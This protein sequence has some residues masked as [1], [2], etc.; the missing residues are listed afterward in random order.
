MAQTVARPRDGN[1]SELARSSSP[2]KV[3]GD[4]RFRFGR[5]ALG[6]IVLLGLALRL[7]RLDAQ[8]LWYDEAY[9]VDL[10]SRQPTEIVFGVI[11]DHLP[12]YFGLLHFWIAQAGQSEFAIRFLSVLFGVAAIPA[13]CV[14]AR[15]LLSPRAGLI[16]AFITT[17]SPYLIHYSQETR[18]YSMVVFQVLVSTYVLLR[19][20]GG[21]RR[22][23]IT[24]AFVAATMAYTHYYCLPFLAGQALLSAIL[25][26][27]DVRRR[28]S[29]QLRCLA[30]WLLA[31]ISIGLVFLP[32]AVARAWV[33]GGFVAGTTEPLSITSMIAKCLVVFSLGHSTGLS[34]V[35]IP[36]YPLSVSDHAIATAS[37]GGFALLAVLGTAVPT[38]RAWRYRSHVSSAS[39]ESGDGLS[40]LLSVVVL[41][42]VAVLGVYLASVGHRDFTARYLTAIVPIYFLILASGLA[43]LW[44]RSVSLALVGVIFVLLAWGYPLQRYFGDERFARDDFRSL[45]TYLAA[46][47]RANEVVVCSGEYW[48]MAVDYYRPL[49]EPC[50]GIVRGRPLDRT[51][52][53]GTLRALTQEREF[54]WLVL[55][56]D[57]V[58]DPDGHL[59]NWLDKTCLPVVERRF[60][61]G[62]RVRGYHTR[63]PLVSEDSVPNRA[64]RSFGSQI[65]LV[66]HEI[67]PAPPGSTSNVILYWTAIEPVREDYVVYVHLVSTP[68]N[69]WAQHDA[70]PL[71]GSYGTSKWSVGQT[72]RDERPLLI[73]AFTPPGEYH[74]EVGLYDSSTGQRVGGPDVDRVVLGPIK[75]GPTL[76]GT[77]L[78]DNVNRFDAR[79]SELIRLVGATDIQTVRPGQDLRFDLYW[80][81][82]RPTG[83]AYTTFIHVV[84]STGHIV[85]QG[86]APPTLGVYPTT[87]WRTGEIIRDPRAVRIPGDLRPGRYEV[88]V[89]LYDTETGSRLPVNPPNPAERFLAAWLKLA[90]RQISEGDALRLAEIEIR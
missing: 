84:D 4:R 24:Y 86:D 80:R 78:P 72:L 88:F 77:Q 18:M 35:V 28:R 90:A 57:Y 23:W 38:I 48:T 64:P 49:D 55:W 15:R 6:L 76:D 63:P 81:A 43:A 14:L 2:H 1:S 33:F 58:S 50:V 41:M 37:V 61:G 17:L 31:E 40:F 20:C 42:S 54:I 39:H 51:M 12:L 36:S 27:L 11:G 22:F 29:D 59:V 79:F 62:I 16:A 67:T 85:A 8:S 89:G 60:Q 65:E 56:Q 21:E 73:P 30:G 47:G 9:S 82:D 52:D 68:H 74:I 7:Y 25:V 71:M 10:A 46:N 69:V 45:A 44:R 53:W 75:I 26:Y 13:S 34:G 19:A 87:S 70:P 3:G 83:S 5:V 32:W 66:G